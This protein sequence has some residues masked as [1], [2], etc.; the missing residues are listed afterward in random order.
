MTAVVGRP[1]AVRRRWP[2][3]LLMPVGP[4]AVA[5]LRLV[6]PYYTA[7]D[8]A[9]SV[10]EVAAHPG[11]ESLVLWLALLAVLTL[12]PGVYALAGL[13]RETSPRLTSWAVGFVV[14]GYLAMGGL[15]YGDQVLWSAHHAK[16]DPSVGATLLDNGHP[17]VDIS[18]GVFVL[19]HVVGTVLL[20]IALLR[21]GR[22]PRWAA[23]ALVVSQP[24]HF[25]ATVILGSPQVDFVG[26]ILTSVG[27]G[28]AALVL[29]RGQQAPQGL[30]Q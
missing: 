8:S 1:V 29:V 12:V 15:L 20:G 27:M 18:I 26:W 19:G 6:L 25:V 7:K 23:W 17:T 22:V 13:V 5:F 10:T 11:R 30:S 14:P 9:A 3:A 16:L 2:V 21:S 28:A 24:I 4:L